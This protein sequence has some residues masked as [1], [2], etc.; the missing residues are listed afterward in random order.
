MVTRNTSADI[1]VG[2][3][4]TSIKSFATVV[5]IGAL[6]GFL[7]SLLYLEISRFILN[8][9]MCDNPDSGIVCDGAALAASWISYIIGA[10]IALIALIIKRIYRPLLIVLAVTIGLWCAPLCMEYDMSLFCALMTGMFALTYG[11]MYWFSLL[12]NFYASAGLITL[13]ILIIQVSLRI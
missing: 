9:F 10:F 3:S 8:Q 11:L 1:R 4:Q 6:V 5:F 13:L 7:T 12:K 2:M